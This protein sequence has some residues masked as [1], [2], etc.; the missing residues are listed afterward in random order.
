M[1]H[2]FWKYLM[3]AKCL[4]KRSQ[5]K[6]FLCA[7]FFI[8]IFCYEQ[9]LVINKSG[10]IDALANS[11]DFMQLYISFEIAFF[12]C[13]V[14][15]FTK[16]EKGHCANIIFNFLKCFVENSSSCIFRDWCRFYSAISIIGSFLLNFPPFF[17]FIDIRWYVVGIFDILRSGKNTQ[18]SIFAVLWSGAQGVSWISCCINVNDM[19]FNDSCHFLRLHCI[20]YVSVCLAVVVLFNS[21]L[22]LSKGPFF[23][24]AIR[25]TVIFQWAS[26]LNQLYFHN[27][28]AEKHSV[29]CYVIHVP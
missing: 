5:M 18:T 3:D 1:I 11:V 21:F 7:E 25:I 12:F 13:C 15:L 6:A 2:P 10:L 8:F 27:Y 20:T 4:I 14:S 19:Y 23:L 29:S 9:R 16:R 28:H 17:A 24:P 22:K 26:I